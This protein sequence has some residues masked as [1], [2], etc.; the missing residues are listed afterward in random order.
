ME[1]IF[2]V[3]GVD[4]KKT[5]EIG[6]VLFNQVLDQEETEYDQDAP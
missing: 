1:T 4:D 5:G 6:I 3:Q 2:L